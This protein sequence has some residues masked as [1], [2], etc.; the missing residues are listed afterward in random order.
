MHELYETQ[1]RRRKL[2]PSNRPPPSRIAF[3]AEATAASGWR[4]RTDA[5]THSYVVEKSE[6][7]SLAKSSQ[8]LW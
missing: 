6:N 1:D 5:A 7:R 4:L 2:G 3:Q 8:F